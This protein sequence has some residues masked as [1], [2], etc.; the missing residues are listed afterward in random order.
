MLQVVSPKESN[1]GRVQSGQVKYC[2]T[3]SKDAETEACSSSPTRDHA[4]AVEN[5]I[6]AVLYNRGNIQLRKRKIG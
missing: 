6:Y 1:I 2:C 3:E 4:G 5:E